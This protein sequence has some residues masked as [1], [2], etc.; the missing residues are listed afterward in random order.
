LSGS[1]GALLAELVEA[2]QERKLVVGRRGLGLDIDTA[3]ALQEGWCEVLHGNDQLVGYKLGLTSPA[4]QATMGISEPI[5]G[6]L[7]GSTLLGPGEALAVDC[8]VQP[9]VEPEVA[10]L[11]GEDIDPTDGSQEMRR[12]VAG[13]MVALEVLDSRF[14]GYRFDLDEVV[15]DNTSAGAW[16]LWPSPQPVPDELELAPVTVALNGKEVAWAA[17][18][19][20]L[21]D[22]LRGLELA[23]RILERQGRRLEAGMVLLTGG[24]TDAVPLDPG[25][26]VRA[27]V[28]GLG[29]LELRR[30][31]AG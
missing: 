30:E 27:E 3:Y 6:R 8:L 18:G 1:G 21:G 20:V 23:A 16:M 25:S 19:A 17:A 13:V 9:R 14:E 29:A 26:V 28:G 24:V 5:L 2:R 10:I 22:P 31:E 12:K 4:K 7:Y 11:V 15:M